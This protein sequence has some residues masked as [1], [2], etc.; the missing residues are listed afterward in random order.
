MLA[1]SA[2]SANNLKL[3]REKENFEIKND[4]KSRYLHSLLRKILQ[5]EK[6]LFINWSLFAKSATI[7]HNSLIVIFKNSLKQ[8]LF[9]T[10]KYSF[11]CL[12]QVN[13]KKWARGLIDVI[14]KFCNKRILKDR[15]MIFQNAFTAKCYEINNNLWLLKNQKLKTDFDMKNRKNIQKISSIQSL[16]HIILFYKKSLQRFSLGKIKEFCP[17]EISLKGKRIALKRIQ[18]FYISNLKRS[19]D[20][21]N[22]QIKWATEQNMKNYTRELA[23]IVRLFGSCII[24]KK[25]NA[26]LLWKCYKDRKVISKKYACKQIN[27]LDLNIKEKTK[28]ILARSLNHWRISRNEDTKNPEIEKI[29]IELETTKLKASSYYAELMKLQ[30]YNSFLVSRVK[31]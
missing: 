31:K 14:D 30:K 1:K 17:T 18:M 10:L 8:I 19:F 29:K 11:E 23:S 16:N 20:K 28:F 21:W 12:T 6:L 9:Q 13:N 27:L 3:I 5:I 15:F 26:F 7:R 2:T 25:S 24:K 4:L 22:L